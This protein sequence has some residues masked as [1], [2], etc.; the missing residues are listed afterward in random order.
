MWDSLSPP[1]LPPPPEVAMH[2][3]QRFTAT[4]KSAQQLAKKKVLKPA[5]LFSSVP[6]VS[7]SAAPAASSSLF[8]S[9][10]AQGGES[11]GRNISILE[12]MLHSMLPYLPMYRSTLIFN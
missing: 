2:V 10:S 12:F 3:P 8:G 1:P 6:S 5:T 4:R 9:F 7:R 11:K